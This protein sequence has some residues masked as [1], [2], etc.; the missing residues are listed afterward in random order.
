MSVEWVLLASGEEME[1]P[2]VCI[3]LVGAAAIKI[4]LQPYVAALSEGFART[5]T[6]TG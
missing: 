1:T 4:V 2:T 5:R 6:A 3:A